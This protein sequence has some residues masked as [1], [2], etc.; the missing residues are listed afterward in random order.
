MILPNSKIYLGTLRVYLFP[1]IQLLK[2]LRRYC[3]YLSF[4]TL[5]YSSFHGNQNVK[6]TVQRCPTRPFVVTP[7]ACHGNWS[8]DLILVTVETYFVHGYPSSEP[9]PVQWDWISAH[10][11]VTYT[12]PWN[13]QMAW[14]RSGTIT[15][16]Y[17]VTK[18]W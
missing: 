8:W 1:F 14:F 7:K 3:K 15:L 12:F 9:V 13:L 4:K 18:Y 11:S 10:W 2:T 17:L 16:L 6:G 5:W